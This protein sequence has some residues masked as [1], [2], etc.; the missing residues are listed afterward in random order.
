MSVHTLCVYVCVFSQVL[1]QFAGLHLIRDEA[2]AE[3]VEPKQE[4]K[5]AEST[6]EEEEKKSEEE[7]QTESA[8]KT[9]AEQKGESLQD[10]WLSEHFELLVFYLSIS[11][12]CCVILPLHVK[13][14]ICMLLDSFDYF[15]YKLICRLRGASEPKNE[16]YLIN[17]QIKKIW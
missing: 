5:E 3:V 13:Y 14:F 4:E 2:A 11:F 8:E 9:A 15:S 12:V 17:N 1:V 7:T 10:V 16:M 6:A